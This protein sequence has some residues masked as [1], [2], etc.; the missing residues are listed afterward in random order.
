L[1]A[2]KPQGKK[3]LPTNLKESSSVR[4]AINGNH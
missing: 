2:Q 4:E 1:L 3:V